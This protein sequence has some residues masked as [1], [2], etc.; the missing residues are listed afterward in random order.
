MGSS[1]LLKTK[2][3]R[4][5]KKKKENSV[6][7]HFARRRGRELGSVFL[8]CPKGEAVRRQKGVRVALH[9]HMLG[10][11]ACVRTSARLSADLC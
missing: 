7:L 10:S 9:R 1:D 11:G 5:R 6:L 2:P 8:L 3:K 4:K